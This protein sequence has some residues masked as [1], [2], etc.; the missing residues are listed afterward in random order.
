M[1]DYVHQVWIQLSAWCSTALRSS[2]LLLTLFTSTTKTTIH[3]I[4]TD[5][6]IYYNSSISIGEGAYSSVFKA[7]DSKR[8]VY[9][10]MLQSKEMEYQRFDDIGST[11]GY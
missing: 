1:M 5:R 7:Y 10:M 8:R 9:A 2:Y 3:F 4:S 6:T 11:K